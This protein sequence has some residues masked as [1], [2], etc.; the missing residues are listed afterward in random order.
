MPN[1]C[2]PNPP[3]V[4][5]CVHMESSYFMVYFR[6]FV[7]NFPYNVF[8]NSYTRN[9]VDNLD[10]KYDLILMCWQAGSPIHDHAESDCV[11]KVSHYVNYFC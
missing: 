7:A 11:M 3:A 1:Y 6:E 5:Y 9:L 8:F 10:G 4:S 2:G